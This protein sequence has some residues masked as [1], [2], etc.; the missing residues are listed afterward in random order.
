MLIGLDTAFGFVVAFQ[1]GVEIVWGHPLNDL[2]V[3]TDLFWFGLPGELHMGAGALAAWYFQQTVVKDPVSRREI[4]YG[5]PK[6]F[7]RAG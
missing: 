3:A 7:T 4:N 1:F 5:T 2:G 6:S